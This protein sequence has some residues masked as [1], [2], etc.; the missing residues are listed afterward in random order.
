MKGVSLVLYRPRA[1]AV[2]EAKRTRLVYFNG[3][4]WACNGF[5]FFVFDGA[6]W[7]MAYLIAD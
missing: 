3:Y 4:I 6:S 2:V 1:L 7:S 5:N